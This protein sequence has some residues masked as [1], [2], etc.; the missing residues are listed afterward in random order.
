MHTW[1]LF[2][3]RGGYCRLD[4]VSTDHHTYIT[5]PSQ[6]VAHWSYGVMRKQAKTV[7][8]YKSIYSCYMY[9]TEELYRV[10]QCVEATF[11]SFSNYCTYTAV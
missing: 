11:Q 3:L 10:V 9:S 2:C 4:V 8:M 5:E 7:Y 6:A 1:W